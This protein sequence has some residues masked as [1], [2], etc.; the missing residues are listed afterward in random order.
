[1]DSMSSACLRRWGGRR[2]GKLGGRGISNLW[3]KK[4][5]GKGIGIKWR[6]R[7]EGQMEEGED[8]QQQGLHCSLHLL[9]EQ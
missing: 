1:V 6:E 3:L 8:E 5:Y 2:L 4:R 7:E 9:F